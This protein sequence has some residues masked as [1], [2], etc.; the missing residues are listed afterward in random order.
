MKGGNVKKEQLT[1]L[2]KVMTNTGYRF[3]DDTVT[4]FDVDWEAETPIAKIY[5]VVA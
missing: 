2:G 1:N 3:E 4:E 5:L